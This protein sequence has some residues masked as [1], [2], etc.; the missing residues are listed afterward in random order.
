[1]AAIFPFDVILFDVGG[2][3]LTNGWDERE[4]A[5][6]AEHFQFDFTEFESRHI[7]CYADWDRDAI[8][9]NEYLDAT[10]FYEPRSF[11]RDDFFTFMHA[12]SKRLPDG[13]LGILA[14]LAASNKCLL[15][16][17]NNEA[18]ETNEYRFSHFGLRAFFKVSLSSCY[19]GLR[20]PEPAFYRRALDILGR[21]AERILFIDDREENVAAAI[22][23]G[24]K[25]IRFEGAESLRR[26]LVRLGVL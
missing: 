1:M 6:A 23:A 22:T 16:A 18:R 13:A 4:R 9:A 8:S 7:A 3:L 5:A 19:L 21:P 26:E 10:I 11:F 17:L 24:M 14:Q 25:A 15:G 2:V 12:Q 20:K